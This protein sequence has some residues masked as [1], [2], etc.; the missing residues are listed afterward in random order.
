MTEPES[1]KDLAS[2]SLVARRVRDMATLLPV[3]G[4]FI[5]SAPICLLALQTGGDDGVKMMLIAIVVV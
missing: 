5:S 2:R 3:A 1:T 4:V